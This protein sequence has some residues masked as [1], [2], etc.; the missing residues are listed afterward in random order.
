MDDEAKLK[1]RDYHRKWRAEHPEQVIAAQARY[2]AKKAQE[3]NTAA[4]IPGN[5]EIGKESISCE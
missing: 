3:Q 4:Q 5:Q 2:W 1:N